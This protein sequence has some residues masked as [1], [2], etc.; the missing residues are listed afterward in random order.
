MISDS[1]VPEATWQAL[2]ELLNA[3][4]WTEAVERLRQ[5]AEETGCNAVRLTLGALLAEREQYFEAIVLWT[6]V[7]ED[8]AQHG[9]RDELAAAYQNLAAAY[10]DLGDYDLAQRFQQRSLQYQDDFGAED[11]LQLAND[12][13]ANSNWSLAESLLQTAAQLVEEDDPL[14]TDLMATAGVVRGLQGDSRTA[15][16]LLKRA[17]RHHLALGDRHAAGRDLMNLA[18]VY[19]RNGRLQ[20]EIRCLSRAAQ[21]FEQAAAPRRHSLACNRRREA[22]RLLAL[23]QSDP[24]AN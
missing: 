9:R 10:R 1:A 12:A 8:A 17:Y 5:L 15:V 14:Q 24:R 7:I 6:R 18:A 16:N 13:L 11:L 20:L 3:G 2:A 23:S 4:Q 21:F 22:T 19:R